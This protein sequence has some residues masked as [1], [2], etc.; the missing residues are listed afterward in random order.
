M[1]KQETNTEG[2]RGKR[3]WI[4]STRHAAAPKMNARMM[5][6]DSMDGLLVRHRVFIPSR[7]ENINR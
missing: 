6:D 5:N 2:D 7:N 1:F 3:M 4:R